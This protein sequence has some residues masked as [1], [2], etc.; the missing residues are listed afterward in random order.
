MNILAWNCCGSGKPGVIPEINSLTRKFVCDIAFIS[1]TRAS[2]QNHKNKFSSLNFPNST[3]V[4]SQGQSGGLWLGWNNNIDLEII[5]SNSRFINT[6]IKNYPVGSSWMCTFVYG[7]PQ[8]NCRTHLWEHLSDMATKHSLP[9][10]I[11]GDLNEI[12]AQKDK[13]GKHPFNSN[14]HSHFLDFLQSASFMDLVYDGVPFTWNNRQVRNRGENLTKERLDRGICNDVWRTLF[15]N[16][17]TTNLPII[18]SKSDHGPIVIRLNPTQNGGPKQ[19]HFQSMWMD[20]PDCVSLVKKSWNFT[21]QGSNPYKFCKKLKTIKENVKSWNRSTFG[22]IHNKIR[23]LNVQIEAL[24]KNTSYNVEAED[25]LQRDLADATN[26]QEKMWRDKSRVLKIKCDGTNSRYFHLSTLGR[27]GRLNISRIKNNAGVWTE[28]E[29]N[30]K[31]IVVNHFKE[32]FSTSE[33]EVKLH[34]LDIIPCVITDEDNNLLSRDVA[35]AEIKEA[36]FSMDPHKAPGPDGFTPFFYQI[37]WDTIHLDLFK[38]I[39]SFMDSGHL[40][41]EWNHTNIALIPKVTVPEAMG[42]FRPI[43]LCN[44]SFRILSK[45]LANRIKPLLEKFISPNQSA[46]VKGRL[47]QDNIVLAHE[48]IRKLK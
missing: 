3:L 5:S 48:I 16:A 17:K 40:L 9:W 10:L 33:P 26:L 39:K 4:P 47:I 13:N 7:H 12:S 45:V 1:E 31:E 43:S 29:D 8:Q 15:P 46:F 23:D 19:F 27:R 30:I 11:V 36:L 25:N 41:K 44:V 34:D 28:G 37:F 42:Q 18:K 2:L 32:L 22:N 21:P 20:R 38:A 24:Q 6:R 35:I 14:L